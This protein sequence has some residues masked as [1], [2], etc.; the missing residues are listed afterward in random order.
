MI[1]FKTITMVLLSI[2][3][4]LIS[5]VGV[6]ASSSSIELTPSIK[7]AFDLTAASAESSVRVK[8]NGL[9]SDLSMLKVQYDS[10][11][12]QIRMLHYNNEQAL[13]VVRQHIKEIDSSK[14]NGLEATVSTTKQRYQPLFDQ[15]SALSRR[16]TIAK[17][18]KDKTL[19]AVL[20]AQGD[21]MKI[22]V[23][24]ARE[25]IRGKQAQLKV[26][27]DART[28]KITAARKTLSGIESPQTSIKSQ[29]SIVTSL[30]K[31]LSAD[32]SDFKAAIRKQSPTLT[33]QSLSSLLSGYR[34]ISASKQKI[35][36]LEQRV[37]VII[38]TTS[39]QIGL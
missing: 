6:L 11:E 27:K 16:I 15:Y 38:S 36:E 3:L 9:Y 33:S 25:D 1:K 10:R 30:N 39:K 32:W 20:S 17:S 5:S 19:N 29:K 24:L 31:R 22:L 21:A 13:I 28:K 23:Q 34:Q 14:V 26:A 18:L 12:E 7:A 37:T 2:L 8:L 4:M 35:I